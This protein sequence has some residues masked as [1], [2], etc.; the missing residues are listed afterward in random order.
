MVALAKCF[1]QSFIDFKLREEFDLNNTFFVKVC[2]FKTF[3]PAVLF[4]NDKDNFVESRNWICQISQHLAVTH[5]FGWQCVSTSPAAVHRNR[6]EL[7]MPD[8]FE[9]THSILYAVSVD[10][11]YRC[12]II[13]L[14]FLLGL[15]LLHHQKE[16]QLVSWLVSLFHR[17]GTRRSKWLLHYAEWDSR[18]Q[19]CSTCF[20]KHGAVFF[21]KAQLLHNQLNFLE[22]K[23]LP[24]N[25]HTWLNN[26]E[27]L[28][29]QRHHPCEN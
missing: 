23:N 12:R 9:K 16:I 21:F 2:T 1:F 22:K 7:G 8:R 5:C 6:A 29:G 28:S 27:Q 4:P 20:E 24:K 26:V 18:C 17:G 15:S 11:I 14:Y 19:C 13:F 25:Q 3:Y 10:V